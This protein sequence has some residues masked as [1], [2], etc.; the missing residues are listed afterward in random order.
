MRHCS[1]EALTKWIS[2]SKVEKGKRKRRTAPPC[3]YRI[4]NGHLRETGG[5]F[6]H[7]KLLF[8]STRGVCCRCRSKLWSMCTRMAPQPGGKDGK[9]IASVFNASLITHLNEVQHNCRNKRWQRHM[10]WRFCDV[11]R[12]W[13]KAK[14]HVETD[15]LSESPGCYFGNGAWQINGQGVSR[16]SEEE[17]DAEEVW[18][19]C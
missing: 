10:K 13:T 15:W 4:R 18:S 8:A 1:D 5:K 12:Q 14:T 3:C 7:T 16:S 2:D 19:A 6:L 17:I 9:R 11:G